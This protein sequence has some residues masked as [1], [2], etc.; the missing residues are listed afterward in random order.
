MLDVDILDD[1]VNNAIPIVPYPV[2]TTCCPDTTRG[3]CCIPTCQG[4]AMTHQC[5]VLHPLNCAAQNGDYSED[6]IACPIQCPRIPCR[7]RG[8]AN[9]DNSG[10]DIADLVY[11]VD[12]MFQGGC[13]P[14]PQEADVNADSNV[15]IADLVHLVDYM[16]NGGPAPVPCDAPPGAAKVSGPT[17]HVAIDLSFAEGITT[18]RVSSPIDLRGIQLELNGQG[19]AAPINLVGDQLD[20]VYGQEGR[21]MKLGLLDLDG[22]QV[23]P[24]GNRSIIELQ[25]DYRLVSATVADNN[26][27]SIVPGRGQKS[28]QDGLPDEYALHQNYPNPFNPTTEISFSIPHTAHVSLEIYNIAGQRVAT[29][30]DGNLNAGHHTVTWDA[31]GAASGVY[32]YRLATDDFDETKKMMLLK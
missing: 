9:H 30:I 1:Y 18:V 27:R 23:I 17:P 3:A 16:F 26:G 12:F 2:S 14:F 28:T 19:P 22:P 25:G 7:L 21:T 5:R 31:S 15:D 24:A 13:E 11:L 20:L 29:L 4:T 10:P 8:D 6:G 32:L